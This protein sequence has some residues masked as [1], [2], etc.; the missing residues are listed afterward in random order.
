MGNKLESAGWAGAFQFS[1]GIENKEIN[2]KFDTQI[3]QLTGDTI[4]MGIIETIKRIERKAE[5]RTIWLQ[6]ACR[7][8]RKHNKCVITVNDNFHPPVC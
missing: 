1:H 2:R 3:E 6:D 5:M 7:L 8:K 4:A